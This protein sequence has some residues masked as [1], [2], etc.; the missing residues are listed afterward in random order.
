MQVT[1]L[2]SS[3]N[4]M[5]VFIHFICFHNRLSDAVAGGLVCLVVFF[6]LWKDSGSLGFGHTRPKVLVRCL[7]VLRWSVESGNT[8]VEGG[9]LSRA[10]VL[11]PEVA[12]YQVPNRL[13]CVR[14]ESLPGPASHVMLVWV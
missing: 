5:Q 6:C 7:F 4:D 8:A 3:L 2:G 14:R 13:R 12:G 10:W 11:L 9:S 1:I